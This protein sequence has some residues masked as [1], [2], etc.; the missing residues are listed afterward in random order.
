MHSTL[1]EEK[2]KPFFMMKRYQWQWW[3]FQQQ[4]K[5]TKNCKRVVHMYTR[6]CVYLE[7]FTFHRKT[8]ICI[9]HTS[10]HRT[11]NIFF[12]NICFRRDVFSY[13]SCA[14]DELSASLLIWF[15]FVFVS[16]CVCICNGV[17]VVSVYIFHLRTHTYTVTVILYR[18][19]QE[20]TLSAW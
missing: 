20:H 15:P 19:A 3:R 4:Q 17:S 7:I 5:M 11:I 16:K 6:V 13:C 1:N 9:T 2:K 8:S 12:F 10:S 18:R 14:F